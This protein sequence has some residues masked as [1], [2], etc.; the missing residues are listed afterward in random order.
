MGALEVSFH[1]ILK[2][3]KESGMLIYE[4][5]GM[6]GGPQFVFNMGGGPGIRVHQFGGGNRARRRPREAG[7]P[8]PQPSLWST[9]QGLLPL[10]I[11]FILPLISSFFGGAD[12][13]APKGPSVRF[14][15]PE[16]P[17]TLHRTSRIY[18]L[19]YW[20][21]PA[22]V[23]DYS[24][25]K[26]NQLDGR[27]EQM[28]TQAL[29]VECEREVNVRQRILDE[30]QGWFYSDQDKLKV[31]RNMELKSCK[32]LQTMGLLPKGSF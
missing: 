20:V 1:G 22:E 25:R 11:L 28:Y 16:P 32:K 10:I 21:N 2:G 18:G 15:G 29:R 17:Q 27:A 4:T 3:D 23:A 19:D 30:A 5:D 8:E 7:Q 6:F 26:F 9:F 31:A 24:A 13:T 12:T 14:T